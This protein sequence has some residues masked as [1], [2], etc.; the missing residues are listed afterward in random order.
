ML[1]DD[2]KSRLLSTSYFVDNG[3]LDKYV[4]LIYDNRLEKHEK[5]YSQCHHG[6]PKC[7]SKKLGES[8]DDSKEN[9]F[10]LKFSVHVLAHV[11]LSLCSID[12]DIKRANVVAYKWMS[13]GLIEDVNSPDIFL[14]IEK[15]QNVYENDLSLCGENHP[16]YGK[17]RPDLALRNKLNPSHLYGEKNGMY[18]KK[19]YLSPNFGKKRSEETKEKLKDS[20]DYSKHITNQFLEKQRFNNKLAAKNKTGWYSYEARQKAKQTK[21]D[22]GSHKLSEETKQKISSSRSKPILC[23]TTGIVYKN[24]LEVQNHTGLDR[25]LVSKCCRG[26]I[27][28]VKHRKKRNPPKDYVYDGTKYRFVFSNAGDCL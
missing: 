18:G 9:L 13:C 21:L 10:E 4:N 15:L 17:K 6:F 26:E 28:F 20:W 19:G 27:E 7:V 12:D 11:Y 3:F 25:K 22:R 8:I 1:R 2:L 14:E 24:A 16:M 5:R 23:I